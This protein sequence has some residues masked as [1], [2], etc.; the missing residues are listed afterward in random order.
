MIVVSEPKLYREWG[1][2]T[3]FGEYNANN[4]V[5]VFNPELLSKEQWNNVGELPESYRLVYI[6]AVVSNNQPVIDEL[7]AEVYS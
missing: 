7:E 5:Y 2:V 4:A 3:D 6:M 1:W